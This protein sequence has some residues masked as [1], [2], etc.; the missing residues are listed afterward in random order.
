[1]GDPPQPPLVIDCGSGGTRV[2]R[3]NHGGSPA[4]QER[5]PWPG[6]GR[7]PVLAQACGHAEGRAALVAALRSLVAENSSAPAS[8]EPVVL[9]GAT[10]GVRHALETG[11]IMQADLDALTEAL[12]LGCKLWV[13][14]PAEEAHYELCATRALSGESSGMLSMG[15][16]SMQIGSGSSAY[17][18][19][20]AAFFGHDE[21]IALSGTWRERFGACRE[22]Y[23]ALCVAV[24]EQQ[25]LP[26]FRGRFV[27]IT[28]TLHVARFA[29]LLDETLDAD[30]VVRA[31]G[32]RLSE[33]AAQLTDKQISREE[34]LELARVL[35]VEAVVGQLF[36]PEAELYFPNLSVSWTAGFFFERSAASHL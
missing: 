11:E 22:K 6:G 24:R 13:L 32:V 19:P 16:R 29:N 14:T 26:Q 20:F 23:A 35:A 1:M 3:Q 25:T 31:L 2:W 28:D 30:A 27:C 18:L 36:A 8:Q 4:A 9:L 5:I 7:A 15:G 12:P 17:S 34:S 10:A 33:S 21:M